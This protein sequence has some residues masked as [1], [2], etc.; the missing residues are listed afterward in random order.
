MSIGS[1]VYRRGDTY[2]FRC[3]VPAHLRAKTRKQDLV[4]AVGTR[5]RDVARL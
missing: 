3:R 5:D 2:S 4:F 1:C